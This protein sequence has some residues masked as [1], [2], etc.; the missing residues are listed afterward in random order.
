MSTEGEPLNAAAFFGTLRHFLYFLR[1]YALHHQYYVE[2]GQLGMS[3][4]DMIQLVR[5]KYGGKFE[6]K[7]KRGVSSWRIDTCEEVMKWDDLCAALDEEGFFAPG[8]VLQ[9]PFYRIWQGLDND[10]PLPSLRREQYVRERNKI[11]ANNA[12]DDDG[13]V[14]VAWSPRRER[15]AQRSPAPHSDESDSG[16]ID[17]S[18]L[19]EEHEDQEREE[20]MVEQERSASDIASDDDDGSIA[21]ESSWR[22]PDQRQELNAAARGLQR[23]SKPPW[24]MHSARKLQGSRTAQGRPSPKKDLPPQEEE[25][26]QRPPAQSA[27]ASSSPPLPPSPPT[28]P[29]PAS[30]RDHLPLSLQTPAYGTKTRE[31]A[32]TPPE[33]SMTAH[34][35][36]HS[37]SRGSSTSRR[38]K[39][40]KRVLPGAWEATREASVSRE[41]PRASSSRQAAKRQRVQ[42][43]PRV[44][45]DGFTVPAPR[46]RPYPSRRVRL[47]TTMMD[48]ALE[49]MYKMNEIV[50]WYDEER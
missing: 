11:V 25:T 6:W 31:R 30:P 33:P 3:R 47:I 18:M 14:S 21:S 40:G 17:T 22:R 48:I 1:N 13:D 28:P 5:D 34:D 26:L 45:H 2:A 19:E 7:G 9:R 29:L 15:Q 36:A 24:R 44:E 16:S 46:P 4:D 41:H 42:T 12:D 43:P 27:A 39:K 23:L 50:D 35:S 37:P 8:S 38:S 10:K 49:Q 32:A 20:Q